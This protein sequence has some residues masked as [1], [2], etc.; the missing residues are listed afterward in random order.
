MKAHMDSYTITNWIWNDVEIGHT[1]I[2]SVQFV[3]DC[4]KISKSLS[5]GRV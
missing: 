4:N 3:G 1:E 2:S 5:G